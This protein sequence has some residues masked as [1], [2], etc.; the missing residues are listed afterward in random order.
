[1]NDGVQFP[2]KIADFIKKHIIFVGCY[3]PIGD[4]FVI[5]IPDMYMLMPV[6]EKEYYEVSKNIIPFNSKIPVA[7]FRGSQTGPGVFYNMT[8]VQNMTRPRLK[9]AHIS[10]EY[11]N[12][13]D[14]RFIDSYNVQNIG[15]EEYVNYMNSKF[16]PVAPREKMKDFN[17][18]MYLLCFDGNHAPPFARPEMIMASGSVPIFQTNYNKYW[19]FLLE[20]KKNYIKIKDDLSDLVDTVNYLNNNKPVAE[21]I[22]NNAKELATNIINYDFIHEYFVEVLNL[23]SLKSNNI[24]E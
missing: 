2:Q 8:V 9:A 12:L 1:L 22:A 11:P 19:S 5:L 18:N 10:L 6:H 24:L 3:S 23:I 20:D 7:K 17:K 15:G 21:T 4:D 14:V 16:G 13:L